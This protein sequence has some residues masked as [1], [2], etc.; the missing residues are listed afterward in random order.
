MKRNESNR[1]ALPLCLL[2]WFC[3]QPSLQ[4]QEAVPSGLPASSPEVKYLVTQEE[5]DALEADLMA[6][7]KENQGRLCPRPVLRG[8]ALPGSGQNDLAGVL[9]GKENEACY[10]AAGGKDADALWAWLE[11]PSHDSGPPAG[12]VKACRGLPAAVSHATR[13]E[14]AC[15]PYLV[16]R[17][18]MPSLVRLLRLSWVLAMNVRML[19]DAGKTAAALALAFDGLRLF[20]DLS[21]GAG[22]PYATGT[23]GG[24]AWHVIV[25]RGIGPTL[26]AALPSPDLLARI[27]QE[28]E[29]LLATEP[30]FC[31]FLPEL[32]YGPVLLWYL[33]VLKGEG[34]V[35]PGG[36]EADMTKPASVPGGPPFG[37][38]EWNDAALHWLV[39]ERRHRELEKAC[40]GQSR[41]VALAKA[42]DDVFV[43][44]S[45]RCRRN[46]CRRVIFTLLAAEPI[47]ELREMLLDGME[48][49]EG[50]WYVHPVVNYQARTFWLQALR[51]Q[52]EFLAVRARTGKCPVEADL[53]DSS[54]EPLLEDCASGEPMLVAVAKDGSVAI[55]PSVAFS[56]AVP[57]RSWWKPRI[58]EYTFVC[59]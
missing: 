22:A 33:P 19:A 52:L 54:W 41:P 57:A 29:V 37:S 10:K 13:H 38:R 4:A 15:S 36:F 9:E 32:R 11:Q 26:S 3:G 40:S 12:I 49:S 20:Q 7:V 59:K 27:T 55:R 21:R 42:F 24:A 17:R 25:T 47:L 43:A 16:G 5:L 50:P 18:A 30:A 39:A 56:T 51:L 28:V 31:D 46:K 58:P 34:W 44:A 53:A 35:P 45:Q 14:D 8:K 6:T 48:R 2:S 23:V 1:L